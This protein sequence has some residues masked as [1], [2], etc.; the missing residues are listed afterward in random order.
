[1]NTLFKI[2]I[3][4]AAAFV[5]LFVWNVTPDFR[6][7]ITWLIVA[8]FICYVMT[9]IVGMTVKRVISVELVELLSRLEVLDRKVTVLLKEALEQR[10]LR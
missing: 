7:L 10:R 4:F 2:V 9:I 8:A 5:G 1:M 6:P 3:W